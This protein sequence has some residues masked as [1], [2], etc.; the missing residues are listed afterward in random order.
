MLSPGAMYGATQPRSTSSTPANAKKLIFNAVLK[1]SVIFV[2]S[3]LV[4]GGTLYFAL[5]TLDE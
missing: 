2:V 5:P 1:M 4:L 3:T